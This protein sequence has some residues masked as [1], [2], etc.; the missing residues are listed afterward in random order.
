M[1]PTQLLTD[2]MQLA[3]SAV[4]AVAGPKGAM[5]VEAAEAAMLVIERLRPLFGGDER[6]Q[7]DLTRG[8]LDRAIARVNAHFDSTIDKL[9][10]KS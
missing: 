10:G 9:T 3:R 8:E 5:Y 4:A 7:L 6:A 2:A 1:T